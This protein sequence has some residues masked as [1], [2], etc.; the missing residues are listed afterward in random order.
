ME[1]AVIRRREIRLAGLLIIGLWPGRG[2]AQASPPLPLSEVACFSVRTSGWNP[3][4]LER[5]G[6]F[7]I[8]TSVSLIPEL[9]FPS[10]DPEIIH[11][12]IRVAETFRAE[13]EYGVTPDIRPW[14]PFW[15]R[16]PEDDSMSVGAPVW[17]GQHRF[18]LDRESLSGRFVYITHSADPWWGLELSD[19]NAPVSLSRAPCRGRTP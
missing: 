10:P 12:G 2:S 11:L 16:H 8:P 5:F 1:K 17:N 3:A 13:F 6:E 15:W 7:P 14:G 19:L 9:A 4:F 18:V